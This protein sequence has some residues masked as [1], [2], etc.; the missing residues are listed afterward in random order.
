MA[1]QETNLGRGHR[2][3]DEGHIKTAPDG[4]LKV[5]AA[6]PFSGVLPED[7]TSRRGP[8]PATM[9]DVVHVAETPSAWEAIE[10]DHETPTTPPRRGRDPAR[11][12]D[13]AER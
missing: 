3:A 4:K 13:K 10:D 12:Q 2:A 7:M 6:R 9:E 1:G 5:T 8:A 11:T